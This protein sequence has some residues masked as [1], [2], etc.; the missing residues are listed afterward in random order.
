MNRAVS[1]EREVQAF[2][3]QQAF[4]ELFKIQCQYQDNIDLDKQRE[5]V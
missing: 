5:E 4:S 1:L 3:K 2:S